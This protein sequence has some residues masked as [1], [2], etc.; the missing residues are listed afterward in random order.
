MSQLSFT[1]IRHAAWVP[2][3]E[4]APSDELVG[5]AAVRYYRF[6]RRCRVDRFRLCPI[7]LLFAPKMYTRPDHV[8]ISRYDEAEGWQSVADVHLPVIEPE[9]W[10]EIDLGGLETDHLRVVCDREHTAEECHGDFAYATWNVPFRILEKVEWTGEPLDEKPYEPPY[11]PPL[12]AGIVRPAAPEGMEL[13][14]T[15]SEVRFGSEKF[16]VA[17]SLR[18]PLI[19]HLAW[20]VLGR[21]LVDRSLICLDS[22]LK[23][24]FSGKWPPQLLC[25]PWFAGLRHDG[26]CSFWTGEVSVEGNRIV[27]H[28][29]HLIEGLSLD[30]EFEVL[31]DGMDV[32]LKQHAQCDLHAAEYEPWRFMWNGTESIT[33]TLGSPVS[34]TGRSG[35]V[36]LPAMWNAPGHGTML[37]RRQGGDPTCLRVD[38]VRDE[39]YGMSGFMLGVEHDE[40]GFIRIRKGEHAARLS[41]RTRE[42]LPKLRVGVRSERMAPGLRRNWST[43]FAFRPELGGFSNN[44]MSVVTLMSQHAAMDMIAATPMPDDE[45]SL[46]DMARYTLGLSLTGGPGYG[47][48]RDMFMDVDPSQLCSAGRI[49]QAAPD[50]RWLERMRPWIRAA[51][52]RI[53]SQ[54][55][56]E[57]LYLC[58]R[59]SGNSGSGKWS[60][61]AYDVVSFGHH[62]AYSNVLAYRGLRNAIA[63]MHDAGE[64]DFSRRCAEAAR[65]IKAAFYPCFFNP[66]T[67]WLGGWRS[68]D[69][70]LHDYAFT[71]ING[72]AICLDLVEGDN[73][74]SMLER[75]EARREEMGY[76]DFH[77]GLPTNLISLRNEDVPAAQRAQREDGLDLFGIYLNGA[78]TTCLLEYY[79][80]ALAKHG[81]AQ[82]AEMICDHLE[83]SLADG[84]LMGGLF[85]GTELSTWEGAPCGYEGVLQG[86][87]RFMLALAEYRGLVEPLDPHWWAA[88]SD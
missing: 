81:F 25:G 52:E 4:T 54:M 31:A 78:A 45:P 7:A 47:E 17:F 58:K 51:A 22:R 56:D 44:C 55:D 8:V 57:G 24:R 43:T 63:L 84:R 38:S 9:Q 6:G 34:D 19:T 85:S 68:R 86:G 48:I 27:Y 46:V 80:G 69:G 65:A 26:S 42:L 13:V 11:Q 18:R 71:F 5:L 70:Q 61:N 37:I 30:V 77:F 87:T 83:E 21:G 66:E 20:D 76:V 28:D 35:L 36:G 49:H 41:I 82:T 1:C 72:M 16:R 33:G 39:F 73:A 2:R 50:K 74:R 59:L 3:F 88:P 64:R 15:P 53:L 75:L 12:K 10:H 14:R 60:S 32:S 29:L 40:Y 23:R 79:F 62:D 67:G